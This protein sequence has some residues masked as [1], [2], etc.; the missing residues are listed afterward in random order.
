M[1]IVF[2]R[3]GKS[4]HNANHDGNYW[5]STNP[6]HPKYRVSNL[7]EEGIEAVHKTAEE[8]LQRGINAKN[9]IAFVSPLPRTQQTA[10]IL[11]ERGVID[12]SWI[13]RIELTELQAGDLESRSGK[14]DENG[15][16]FT[17][18]KK[19]IAK[20]NAGFETCEKTAERTNIFVS[21][22]LP[23]FLQE[24][25]KKKDI[26][27]IVIISHDE[28]LRFLTSAFNIHDPDKEVIAPGKYRIFE[29][30]FQ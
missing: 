16:P 5:Y 8:L 26:E 3:H 19:R 10:A 11:S 29:S 9:S 25:S 23:Y 28:P 22:V 20:E 4:T 17:P 6:K 12:Q 24:H 14:L 1:N 7:L 21:E 15:I 18:E 13:T 2:V 27:N 30:T